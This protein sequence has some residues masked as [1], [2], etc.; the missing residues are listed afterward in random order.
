VCIHEANS[1]CEHRHVH[2]ARFADLAVA[3]YKM[4][5]THMGSCGAKL[6]HIVLAFCL[7]LYWLLL[8]TTR[9]VVRV[10]VII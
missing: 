1:G 7:T 9:V 4:L 3:Q 8:L 10:V 2:S 5:I 6:F